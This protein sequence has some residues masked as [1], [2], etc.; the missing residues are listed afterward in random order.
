MKKR[1][2]IS[3]TTTNY[4]FYQGWFTQKDLGDDVQLEELSFLR[5]NMEDI[6][7]CD[8]FILTGGIDLDPSLYGGKETYPNK[9][10]S[11]Q[12]QRDLFESR[13]FRYAQMNKIPLLGICRGMQLIN[14]LEGGDLVQDLGDAN[15]IH[16]KKEEKDLEHEIDILPGSLL[17]Q[18]GN[19]TK[20]LV[21]SAHHQAIDERFIGRGLRVNAY[22]P[23]KTVEGLEYADKE[24]NGFML[25]VQ[26]HPERLKT[27]DHIPFSENIKERFLY[28]V[29]KN[30]MNKLTII[31]PATE[32]VI[33]EINEDSKDTI[34]RK[35]QSLKTGQ[36][37]WSAQTTQKRIE[38]LIRFN[39]LLEE[40]K[41]ELAGL[42]TAETGK[43]LQQ[44]YNELNGARNRIRFFTEHAPKYLADEWITPDGV[45]KEKIAYEPLGVIGNISAWN[46][47][48]L[49]GVNVFIPA[50]AAGNSVFYKPSE[51]ATLTGLKIQ[52]LLY[53][54]GIP[55]DCF[56]VAIG[57]GTVGAELLQLPLNGY[58][59]TGSYRTG[60]YIHEAVA[61]KLVPCQLELGGKDPLYVMDDI[62]DLESAVAAVLEGVIYNNGQSCCAVE[63]V[64]VH[65]GIYDR[66]VSS[67]VKQLA[68][69]KLGDPTDPATEIGPLSR[70]EQRDF[71]LDQI[72]D[73]VSKGARLLAGGTIPER[74]GYFMEPAVLTQVDHS[75]KIMTEESFGPVIGIQ[76][77]RDDEEALQLMQDTVYGLTAAVYS[78]NFQRAESI[79]QRMNTGTVYW[80]CCDRVSAT[81][82]WS[83]RKHSGLGSTLSYHGIR[84]FT[85]PKAYHLRG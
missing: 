67:Y 12:E 77:V 52:E 72:Q 32:T 78:R 59:F 19:R 33:T 65:E 63:R 61:H 53:L 3:F 16:R 34:D 69:L 4:P 28:E 80:N 22:G 29:R 85:V 25:C 11:H 9:P 17:H 37:A 36:I 35:Y 56:Q 60:K 46:Y 44:A 74:K 76:K 6:Y 40:K 47:P 39:D 83:G 20:G 71:L 5:N 14:V 51:Y 73:A 8:G 23:D 27:E 15:S 75:M 48:Y 2:G 54:S 45:T 66:F 84:A 70:K 64:Y 13:I 49:V 26:W 38:C 31:N 43:P 79:L 42:L 18:I 10:Q 57:R 82:P 68:L 41:E 7:R 55:Q 50:L 24:N 1:I 81:L 21:N 58:Y 30:N 62:E